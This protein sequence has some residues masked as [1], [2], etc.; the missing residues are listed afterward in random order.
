MIEVLSKVG[1]FFIKPYARVLV[2]HL[3][4]CNNAERNV[5]IWYGV[6][7]YDRFAIGE[8]QRRVVQPGHIFPGGKVNIISDSPSLRG[9]SSVDT[10]R[11]TE[12]LKWRF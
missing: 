2:S 10:T 1:W 9:T 12:A 5:Q 8:S 6:F 4:N 3:A 7:S 11:R